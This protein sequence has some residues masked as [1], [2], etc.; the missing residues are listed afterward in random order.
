[1]SGARRMIWIPS[2][3]VGAAAATAVGTGAAVLLYDSQG[4]LRAVVVLGGVIALSVVAGL[5][6]GAVHETDESLSTAARW[7]MGLLVAL[8][9]GAAFAGLWEWMDGL[10]RVPV[11]QGLGLAFTGALPAYFAGGV[12]GRI[13]CFA[14]PLGGGVRW[15]VVIGAAVGTVAGAA[16]VEALL[17]RPVLA[18]TAFLAATVFAS[19]GARFQGWIVDRVPRRRAV[20]REAARPELRFERWRTAVP[21]TEVRVLRDGGRERAVDPPAAGDW[22]R[23]VATTLDP[24]GAVLF[25]GAGAWFARVGGGEWRVHEPDADVGS[26]AGEGFGWP[27]G[28]LSES[29]IPERPGCTVIAD[30]E[31]SGD[32]LVNSFTIPGLLAAFREVGAGRVWIGSRPG[33]LPPELAEMG[34]EA[35]FAITRY[36]ATAAGLVGPPRVESRSRDVLCLDLAGG[37]PGPVRGM[38]LLSPDGRLAESGGG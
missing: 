6:M 19:G 29:P 33:G 25:V 1:M 4:L 12:L 35:G 23:G 8:L 9:A 18:V 34:A 5:R 11:S 15:Q 30:W 14:G 32:A 37:S 2:L 16:L 21:G 7:W 28:S 26:M 36:S 17:G 3:L 13:G 27:A 10:G 31:N 22:R 20:L 38:T 24:A